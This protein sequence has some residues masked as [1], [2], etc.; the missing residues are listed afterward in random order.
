MKISNIKE[1]RKLFSEISPE[2]Q[3]LLKALEIE[4]LSDL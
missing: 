1:L 2:A 3:D 4:F